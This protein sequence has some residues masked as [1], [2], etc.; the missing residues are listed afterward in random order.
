MAAALPGPHPTLFGIGSYGRVDFEIGWAEFERDVRWAHRVLATW[1]VHAG[2]HVVLSTPNFE[3]PWTSPLVRALRALRTV[4]SNVEPYNWDARRS[5]TFL[6]LL[7]VTAYIG[8][9]G[10]IA[11]ALLELESADLLAGVPLLWARPDA[12]AP[13]RAHGLTPAVFAMLGPA[14]ALECPQRAG[15]HLDPAEWLVEESR[16]TLVLTTVGARAHL[17]RDLDLGTTGDVDD[18]PCPCGLPGRRVRLA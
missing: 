1:D 4:H 13:L 18:S 16:G 12:L 3:G 9:S 14:L 7:P 2:D 10:P 17:T 8:L 11:T 5:A 15:A 6:R